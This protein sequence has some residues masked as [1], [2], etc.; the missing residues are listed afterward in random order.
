MMDEFNIFTVT[1]IDLNIKDKQIIINLNQDVD[2]DTVTQQNI[3]LINIKDDNLAKYNLIVKRKQIIIQFLDWISIN[4]KYKLYIQN[5]KSIIDVELESGIEKIIKI[6]SSFLSTITITNPLD[7]EKIH[8]ND[9]KVK[10]I[11]NKIDKELHNS[12]YIELSSDNAFYNIIRKNNIF[13]QNEII[14][15]D[16]DNGQYFIRCRVQ[17]I[18]GDMYGQWSESLSFI[19]QCDNKNKCTDLPNDNPVIEEPLKI[20]TIPEN[21]ETPKSFLISFDEPIDEESIKD[22]LCIR[23]DL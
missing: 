3:Y 23:S 22:I 15:S 16:L 17:D 5:L 7:L 11:E 8:S 19:K 6:N 20:L 1:T 14:Y 21:G 4:T 2:K 12:Y 9:I 10:W 18:K 13:D